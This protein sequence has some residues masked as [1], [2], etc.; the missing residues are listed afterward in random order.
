MGRAASVDA[1]SAWRWPPRPA[2][3]KTVIIGLIADV[4]DRQAGRENLRRAGDLPVVPGKTAS[5]FCNTRAEEY[6]VV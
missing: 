1:S 4:G 3:K 5:N 6:R 2:A